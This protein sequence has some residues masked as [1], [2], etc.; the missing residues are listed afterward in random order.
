MPIQNLGSH[1]AAK[2]TELIKLY[3]MRVRLDGCWWLS[4]R[5]FTQEARRLCATTQLI[6][7]LAN[8]TLSPLFPSW[9]KHT[10]KPFFTKNGKTE[11]KT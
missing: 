11:R 1:A 2:A 8:M 10:H 5:F 7:R 3:Y 4:R 6:T 9:I